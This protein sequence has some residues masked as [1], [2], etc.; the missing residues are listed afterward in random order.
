MTAAVGAST[1]PPAGAG[2]Q[3][4]CPAGTASTCTVSGGST[5][6]A[7]AGVATTPSADADQ[8]SSDEADQPGRG[9]DRRQLDVVQ[10]G[11]L[12]AGRRL[13]EQVELGLDRTTQT[14]AVLRLEALECIDVGVERV[15]RA[16]QPA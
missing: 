5:G 13:P 6:G 7:A 14:V 9:R 1:H 16:L 4:A 12:A 3:S 11:A 8:L 15:A 2:S 10:R